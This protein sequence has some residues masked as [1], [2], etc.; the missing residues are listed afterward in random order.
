[1]LYSYIM[2]GRSCENWN[3]CSISVYVYRKENVYRKVLKELKRNFFF[4]VRDI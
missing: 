4:F 1:M 2:T 3:V